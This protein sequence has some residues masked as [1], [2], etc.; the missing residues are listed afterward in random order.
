MG[1]ICVAPILKF[2]PTSG[3]GSMN[4]QPKKIRNVYPKVDLTSLRP[5]CSCGFWVGLLHPKWWL[6]ISDTKTECL[7]SSRWVNIFSSLS[8]KGLMQNDVLQ[9]GGLFFTCCR[10]QFSHPTRY[11]RKRNLNVNPSTDRRHLD[12]TVDGRNPAPGMYKTL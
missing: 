10:W 5:K 4:M 2:F 11:L 6:N 3:I 9:V 1:K 12:H 7:H 8:N